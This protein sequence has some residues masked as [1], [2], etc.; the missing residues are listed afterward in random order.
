MLYEI[1]V[2]STVNVTCMCR[3]YWLDCDEEV[4]A[5]KVKLVHLAT[6]YMY[7][8]ASSSSSIDVM[9]YQLSATMGFV[10]D[11]LI[12]D[13]VYALLQSRDVG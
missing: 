11:A 2:C 1:P 9:S 8:F 6:L 3:I 10:M 7:A 4:H 5:T 12:H 13:Y